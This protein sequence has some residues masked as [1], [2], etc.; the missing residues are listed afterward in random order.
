M[1][2][3]VSGAS[4]TS[5]QKGSLKFKNDDMFSFKV[6]SGPEEDELSKDAMGGTELMKYGLYDRLPEDLRDSVQIIC[7][8]VRQIDEH[9][10][11][12]LWLHDLAEDPEVKDLQH[13]KFRE[14]FDKLVFVSNWQQQR[15]YQHLGVPYEDGIVLKNAIEPFENIEKPNDKI[16]LIYHTTPHRGLDILVAAFTK[17]YEDRQDIE[18]DVYSSF[19]L[20]GW[21]ERDKP[22]EELFDF[23]RQHPGI[24]YHGSVDNATVRTALSKA[25]IFAY[26]SV[27]QETSCISAIEAL[28][29]GCLTVCPNYAALPET[30]ANFAWMYTWHS[31]KQQHANL[32]AG[33]LKH[34][35]ENHDRP[36]VKQM[37]DLQRVYFNTFYNWDGRVK[38]W[39]GL[40]EGVNKGYQ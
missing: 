3:K 29:A 11:S 8:R 31:D 28:A 24:N 39:H 34:A 16:R 15:Y 33:V 36:D 25:H 17:L 12:I 10:P 14:Q 21:A 9:R 1:G 26:P 20:Y 7:S 40:L 37:L 35:I 22:Y 6:T 32:F 13:A 5:E 38:E 27:W 4:K 30:C 2:K 23:C 19:K 18:L